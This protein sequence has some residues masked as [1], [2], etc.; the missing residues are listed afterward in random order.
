MVSIFVLATLLIVLIYQ[1]REHNTIQL[2]WYI[3][4]FC[5]LL[6]VSVV[7]YTVDIVFDFGLTELQIMFYIT[8]TLRVVAIGALMYISFKKFE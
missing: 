6:V 8:T 3:Y 1:W 5:L 7:S 2:Y 4:P